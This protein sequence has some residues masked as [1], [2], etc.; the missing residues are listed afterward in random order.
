MQQKGKLKIL[1]KICLALNNQSKARKEI[2]KTKTLYSHTKSLSCAPFR[3]LCGESL[4][5]VNTADTV[6]GAGVFTP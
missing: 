5:S 1:I 4:H 3:T 6:R 2:K